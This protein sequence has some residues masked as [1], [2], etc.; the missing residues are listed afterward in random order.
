[1]CDCCKGLIRQQK[2]QGV[3]KPGPRSAAAPS[4][5]VNS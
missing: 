5:L 2:L 3:A 4:A 1:L